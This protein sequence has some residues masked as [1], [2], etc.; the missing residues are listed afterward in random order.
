MQGLKFTHA[1]NSSTFYEISVSSLNQI[2]IRTMNRFRDTARIYLF[3]NSYYVDEAPFGFWGGNY[4]FS[5]TLSGLRT[6][7]GFGVSRDSSNVVSYSSRFDFVSQLDRFNQIKTGFEFIYSD[8]YS[9][10]GSYDWV[11]PDGRYTNKWHKYPVR[12][13]L[14]VQDKLEFEEWLQMLVSV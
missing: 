8:N 3:G 11:L 2:I 6:T 5:T 7:I 12:G 1:L 14:Y 9:N 10:Y 4:D 13:A